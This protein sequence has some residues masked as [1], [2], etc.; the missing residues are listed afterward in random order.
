MLFLGHFFLCWWVGRWRLFS[1]LMIVSVTLYHSFHWIQVR[2]V[3][4]S[5]LFENPQHNWIHQYSIPVTKWAKTNVLKNKLFHGAFILWSVSFVKWNISYF[6]FQTTLFSYIY[7]D[8]FSPLYSS[9][10]YPVTLHI[11]PIM[12]SSNL[13]LFSMVTC[14]EEI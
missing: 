14:S 5:L 3:A 1:L 2:N 6:L 13:S 10:P 7:K 11:V 8:F 9:F 4:L 12:S